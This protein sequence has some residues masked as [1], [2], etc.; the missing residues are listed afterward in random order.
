[1]WLVFL[2][3]L[4]FNQVDEGDYLGASF[5]IFSKNAFL[6]AIYAACKILNPTIYC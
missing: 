6:F 5:L 2:S 4:S 1:M 3:Y